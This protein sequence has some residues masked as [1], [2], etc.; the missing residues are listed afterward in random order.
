MESEAAWIPFRYRD[1][2]DVPRA[3]V[4]EYEGDLYLFDCPFD[5]EPT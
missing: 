2:H 1:F 3:V 5:P 4:A